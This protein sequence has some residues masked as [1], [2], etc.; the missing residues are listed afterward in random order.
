MTADPTGAAAIAAVG[1]GKRG[2][3]EMASAVR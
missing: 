3:P 2:L 1:D